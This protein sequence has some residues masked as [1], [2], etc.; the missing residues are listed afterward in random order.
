MMRKTLALLAAG[1]VFAA[2]AAIATIIQPKP[3]ATIVA[4]ETATAHAPRIAPEPPHPSIAKVLDRA[5]DLHLSDFQRQQLRAL[6]ARVQ[7]EAQ[8]L[9]QEIANLEARLERGFTENHIDPV[10]IDGL[11][12]RIGQLEGR[13]RATRLMARLDTRALLLPEQLA[14]LGSLHR[15]DGDM[16]QASMLEADPLFDER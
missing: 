15:N 5:D 2:G 7:A 11:T 12:T 16:P 14:Q 1:A 3:P 4:T 13:L 6:S 8:A 9:R 10:R